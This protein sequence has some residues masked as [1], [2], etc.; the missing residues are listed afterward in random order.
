[1]QMRRRFNKGFKEMENV[2]IWEKGILGT[3]NSQCLSFEGG[4]AS[5]MFENTEAGMAGVE[6][7]TVR[8][9]ARRITQKLGLVD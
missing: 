2:H 6:W 9:E 5:G 8:D 4:S 1:M 3:G 7:A